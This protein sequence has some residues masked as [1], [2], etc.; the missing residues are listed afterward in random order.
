MANLLEKLLRTGEGRTLKRL[1]AYTTAINNLS[2]EFEALSDAE[3]REETDRFRQR[4]EDGETLDAL[5]P[6][7]FAA[8]RE[9]SSRTVGLRHFDVQLMGGAAL[10]L[11]NI[12]EMK[13]G[14]GKTLVATAPAYLNALSG[15]G[16][17]II[18]VNDFLAEYQSNLMGRVF[19]FLGME[20][21]CIRAQMSNDDRRTQYAADITYG[22]NNEFGFDYLR[23][24]M[25][26]SVDE[27]VQR[28]HNFVIVDE[29]DSILIDEART[30]LIISGPSE[31]GAD[32]WYG[33][34]AR[35]VKRLKA[36]R[37]YEVDE[38]KRTVGIL[39][40]GIDRV[41]D[42]LGIGNLYDA[43]NTPLISF[44]NNA[45]K[46]K[47]LFKK[48]K[49]YVVLDGE[50]LIVDEHTGRILKGRRYNEGL[51]QSIEAK[52]GVDVKAENQTLA[53]ITLQNY[54]RLYEKLSGMTGTA[55]TEA[56]EFMSTYKL[57]VVPIPTNRPMQR[58]DH[59]D[60]VYKH[61]K[62]KFAAIVDDIAEA[63]EAGQPVLVGTTSVDKSEYLSK[64]LSK[65]GIRHEVLNAKNHAREAAIV[66]MA[67]R[68]GAV[69]VA[70]NM[71]GRGTDIMLG[72][73]AEF[74]AVAAMESKGLDARE[75][76]E[77]YEAAWPEVLAGVE[78]QVEEEAAEVRE[79]GGLYVLGTERHESR[80]IDNQLMGRSG[81]QGDPGDSR[82]YL[83]LTDDLMRLFGSGAAERI[84]TIANVPDDMP[85]ETKMVSRAIQSAQNQVEERNA[86]QRK[87]VLK[88]DDVLNRQR[89]VIYDERR[90]VLEGADLAQQV[91]DFREEVLSA[92]VTAA[93]QGPP[94]S[95]KLDDLFEAVGRLYT[96]SFTAEEL[97]EDAG[98]SVTRETLRT[99]ILTDAN[100][101]Y[102]RREETLGED[103]TRELER[104]VMLSV[105]D[106]RWRE[107]LY[108]MDY[109]KNGIGLRAMAQRD[110][111]VEYQREGYEMFV[112]MQEGIREDVVRL[113]NTLE[114][115]VREKPAVGAGGAQL[116]AAAA[117]DAGVTVEADELK[118]K[119]Q[120]L[121]LSAPDES[122]GTAESHDES[123]APAPA[124]RA[125]RRKKRNGS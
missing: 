25:A 99:E 64:M 102:E 55:E 24:N 111:L 58:V 47:E 77:A 95:W 35:V 107:H 21:G 72:G 41:E 8:V 76:P 31:G 22:T 84:M 11:G 88:Y 37:D 100:L 61:E 23:D 48:D 104:R 70:T 16:V 122:G 79:A 117:P 40:P 90:R 28:G 80:R 17:H 83:S 9:A 97:V 65:R 5:L 4:H 82:F 112:A 63:H 69:T 87:N 91:E 78:A 86:E 124:N 108:E 51:H 36:E 57:G 54:F 120:Q 66:A 14:E 74:L 119:K 52:E 68:K 49:D 13:T 85:L 53:T 1:R 59:A 7:A 38:K 114:V 75:D 62:A 50:V 44:L 19:R 20:T 42:Y 94:D 46:A 12:A 26:W 89:T 113:T 121:H 67:G 2:D 71:A 115:T 125:Q 29:V 33:E 30:P 34:F 92:Y 106:R 43:D 110:P 45:I 27:M 93:T 96:P 98:G 109:L 101:F 60:V 123:E 105:I 15:K 116:G 6:E 18:T 39:E 10:H 32:R 81:R 56:G 103:A 73:N 118:P 3:L